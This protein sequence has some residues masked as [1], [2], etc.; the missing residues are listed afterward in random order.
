MHTEIS[1]KELNNF[2]SLLNFL[3]R[4]T[5]DGITPLIE[6]QVKIMLDQSLPFFICIG[7]ELVFDEITRITINKNILGSNKRIRE[8]AHLKYPPASLVKNY[9]RCNL[10]GQ[11]ILYGSFMS[12]T[13]MD[14]L[15]PKEG[16][17]YTISTW[18]N[19][20]QTP[21]SFSPIFRNQPVKEN[22]INPRTIEINNEY[23]KATHHF[24]RRLKIATDHLTQFVADAFS[25]IITPGN[26]LDYIFSA[27]FSNK[28][29]NDINN[30]ILDAIYYPSVKQR[31]SFENLA[32]KPQVFDKIYTLV[33]VKE[34]I[35]QMAP[36]YKANGYMSLGISECN[37]FDYDAGKILWDDSSHTLTNELFD[38]LLKSKA[39]EL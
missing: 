36:S 38:S 27:Y 26:N 25:K 28:I 17:L 20:K 18:K 30:G 3:T 5:E 2:I 14:E 32:I 22:T 4:L 9:G 7:S 19:L 8:I 11:S 1:E 15:R 13:A 24:P 29:F 39:L 35:V 23:E 10:P 31:L 21:L 34:L 16:D 33:K 6:K 12:N 37:K